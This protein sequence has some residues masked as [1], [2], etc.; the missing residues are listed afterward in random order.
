MSAES[1]L[2][3]IVASLSRLPGVGRRSAERMA[4]RLV[5]DRER[6]LPELIDA[7]TAVREGCRCC[8]LCG[9]LT[10][11]AED[12]CALCTSPRRD[13]RLLCVVEQPGDILLI[14]RSGGFHGRYHA[15][16]GKISPM[17]GEGPEDL[18]FGVLLERVAREQFAEV[19]LALST[20]VEGDA[21]ASFLAEVL[22]KRGVA[23][24][25]LASGLPARSGIAYSDA[26][27]LAKAIK[28]RQEA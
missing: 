14:E 11:V 18:R 6:L 22:R 3:R 15:L 20:D 23:V 26:V 28:G 16:M 17:H 7:L 12:P 24:S 25:R 9:S 19:I 27:T 13:G 2:E 5:L 1:P 4:W 10:S 21:T 8:S